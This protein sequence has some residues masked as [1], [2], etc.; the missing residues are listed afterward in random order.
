MKPKICAGG[1]LLKDNKFLF[2][3]RSRDKKWAA[4]VWDIVGGH[5]EKHE[6][7]YDTLKRETLEETGVIVNGAELLSVM[8]VRDRSKAGFF[9]YYVYMITEWEGK[10]EN[11]SEEHSA[12]AW[13]TLEELQRIELALPEYISLA[14]AWLTTHG[15]SPLQERQ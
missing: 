15:K 1:F 4:G 5:A 2:G 8:E 13:F 10:P 3:K 11:C 14:E 12:L 7:V 9:R 6:D